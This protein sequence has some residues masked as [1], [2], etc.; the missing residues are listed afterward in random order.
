M[1][2]R[3][4]EMSQPTKAKGP[5]ARANRAELIALPAESAP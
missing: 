3:D 5:T 4:E 2:G 1:A